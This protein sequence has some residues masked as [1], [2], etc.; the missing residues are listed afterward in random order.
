MRKSRPRAAPHLSRRSELRGRQQ[1]SWAPV[2]KAGIIDRKLRQSGGSEDRRR[3]VGHSAWECG[4]GGVFWLLAGAP[5]TRE[6]AGSNPAAP[7]GFPFLE[8]RMF[9]RKA[10]HPARSLYSPQLEAIGSGAHSGQVATPIG[11][12]SKNSAI[13]TGPPSREL[14]YTTALSASEIACA[15]SRHN[16]W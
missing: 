16:R 10:R 9:T 14:S 7:I 4:F 15:T 13:L 5:H 11:S 8:P 6:V 2:P 1:C 12:P 3:E